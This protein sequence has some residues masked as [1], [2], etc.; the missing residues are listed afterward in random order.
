MGREREGEYAHLAGNDRYHAAG[1]RAVY[2][3]RIRHLP[4][5][6]GLIDDPL[7]RHSRIMSNIDREI[8]PKGYDPYNSAL[9]DRESALEWRWVVYLPGRVPYL[10]LDQTQTYRIGVFEDHAIVAPHP[11]PVI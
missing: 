2:A 8:G 5:I 10:T 4:R 1:R 9:R 6:Q 11:N 3:N 7:Q